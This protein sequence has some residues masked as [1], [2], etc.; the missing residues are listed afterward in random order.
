MFGGAL[1]TLRQGDEAFDRIYADLR[2]D[3][4]HL[5]LLTYQMGVQNEARDG[6]DPWGRRVDFGNCGAGA[7]D[8]EPDGNRVP[9]K[10]VGR[11]LLTD[12]DEDMKDYSFLVLMANLSDKLQLLMDKVYLILK[13]PLPFAHKLRYEH[14]ARQMAKILA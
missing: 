7:T 2:V 14:W 4:V 1:K 13:R 5:L 9:P 3:F 8:F 10:F 12:L 11:E 6:S